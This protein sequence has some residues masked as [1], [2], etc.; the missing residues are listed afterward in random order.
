M[1]R[2]EGF[3]IVEI[4][5]AILVLTVGLMAV[6][7]TSALVTRMIGRGQR[8]AAAAIFA[9]Q[10]LEILRGTACTVRPAGADTLY[11]GGAW[12]AINSWTFTDAGKSTWRITVTST[13]KTAAG[14]TRVDKSETEV[15]CL[16]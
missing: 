15:S 14:R 8:S 10:R 16:I 5:V 1:R 11:R 9:A 12:A 7:G 2:E 4:I 13:Y 6:A 3:T